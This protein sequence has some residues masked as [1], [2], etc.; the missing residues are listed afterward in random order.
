MSHNHSKILKKLALETQNNVKN[1][2]NQPFGAKHLASH[3]TQSFNVKKKKKKENFQKDFNALRELE[4]M[5]KPF[6]LAY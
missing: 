4:I 1:L 3:T 2:K 6:L 5:L